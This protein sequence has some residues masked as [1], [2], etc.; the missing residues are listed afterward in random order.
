M[1]K[2]SKCSFLCFESKKERNK[3]NEIKFN[4]HFHSSKDMYEYNIKEFKPILEEN[5]KLFKKKSFVNNSGQIINLEECFEKDYEKKILQFDDNSFFQENME[6]IDYPEKSLNH[7]DN[8]MTFYTKRK[9][10]RNKKHK[11][12]INFTI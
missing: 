12:K 7:F 6:L 1:S 9:Y 8:V 4:N 5:L 11:S 3:L 2:K 10:E